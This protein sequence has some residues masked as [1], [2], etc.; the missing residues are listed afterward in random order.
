MKQ[1]KDI[2]RQTLFILGKVLNGTIQFKKI[3]FYKNEISDITAEAH[4]FGR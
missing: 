4:S 1:Q 3:F 2:N